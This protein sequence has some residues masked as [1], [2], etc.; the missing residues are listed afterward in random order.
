MPG[1]TAFLLLSP[2]IQKHVSVSAT[3]RSR[4]FHKH[5]QLL[6]SGLPQTPAA[7]AHAAVWGPAPPR[8]GPTRAEQRPRGL[9]SPQTPPRLPRTAPPRAT[10]DGAPEL[11]P[12]GPAQP[13]AFSQRPTPALRAAAGLGALPSPPHCPTTTT[14]RPRRPSPW[15]RRRHEPPPPATPRSAARRHVT[16]PPAPPR[17]S[18]APPPFHWPAPRKRFSAGRLALRGRLTARRTGRSASPVAGPEPRD[19]GTAGGNR[20]R[21]GWSAARYGGWRYGWGSASRASS[22]SAVRGSRASAGVA[23]GTCPACTG[24]GPQPGHLRTRLRRHLRVT[25]VF[26]RKAEEYLRLSQVKCAGLM[27]HVTASGLAVMC[28]ELAARC[29]KHPA[30]KVSRPQTSRAPHGSLP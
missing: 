7:A 28:L 10:A 23:G 9:Q 20:E 25:A 27:A 4:F 29:A 30:G 14:R 16:A 19:A 3:P 12:P 15:S 6:Q 8:L 21:G 22:G 17:P 2:S 26:C 1:S 24:P 11:Q 13:R 5:S 18:A